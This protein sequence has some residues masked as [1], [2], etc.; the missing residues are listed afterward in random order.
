MSRTRDE[1]ADKSVSDEVVVEGNTF[2]EH[3]T[4]TNR[5]ILGRM[6][7]DSSTRDKRN[8]LPEEERDSSFPSVVLPRFQ[9]NLPRKQRQLVG[10]P[11]VKLVMQRARA[12]NS[13]EVTRQQYHNYGYA[14]TLEAA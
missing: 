3:S 11:R 9:Q 13:N 7:S 4:A 1:F 14:A 8:L 2:H 5:R 12:G 6:F 10:V